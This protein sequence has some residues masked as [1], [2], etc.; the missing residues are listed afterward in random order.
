MSL[1]GHGES[2][3]FHCSALN[4][5][6]LSSQPCG[7]DTQMRW[8][9]WLDWPPVPHM[10]QGVAHGAKHYWSL[11]NDAVILISPMQSLDVESRGPA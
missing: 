4:L 5:D 9:G 10:L 8:S 6:A 2:A 11:G 3:Q 7:I 1:E